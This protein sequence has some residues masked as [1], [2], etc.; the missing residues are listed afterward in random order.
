MGT[1]SNR[2]SRSGMKQI[3][4]ISF[5]LV[6]LLAGCSSSTL[7]PK[8]APE[9]KR[10]QDASPLHAQLR[11]L[12]WRVQVLSRRV[13]AQANRSPY[14]SV[15]EASDLRKVKARLAEL[16]AAPRPTGSA[17]AGPD[18][19]R[20]VADLAAQLAQLSGKVEAQANR[21]PQAPAATASDLQELNTRLA[22][23]EA[24]QR[25]AAASAAG[26]D[27]KQTIADLSGKLA[28]LS[29]KLDAQAK[30][31]PQASAATTRGLKEL[32]SRLGNLEA[33]QRSAASSTSTTD[34]K[35]TV[36]DLAGKI[37]SLSRKIDQRESA[38]GSRDSAATRALSQS[39]AK[40]ETAQKSSTSELKQLQTDLEK[41][42]TLVID[43]LEDLD[44]RIATLE[45]A[46]PPAK[47]PAQS[48]TKP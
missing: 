18:L 2:F 19:Q 4:I 44:N 29:R 47:A 31:P 42:R 17:A 9:T 23:L 5:A 45:K 39:L 38:A 48:P 11:K 10:T 3:A 30:R 15:A 32:T 28:Q 13:K 24:A 33:A 36:A 6:P 26:S 35:Q 41:D 12:R 14:A 22:E 25:S 37:A 7:D 20:T 27:T 46:T 8:L 34:L 16:E 1:C 43:Y 40:I 21:P